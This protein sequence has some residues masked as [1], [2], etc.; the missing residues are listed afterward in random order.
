M[1]FEPDSFASLSQ[2]SSPQ[3][4]PCTEIQDEQYWGRAGQQPADSKRSSVF[5]R[6]Y[7]TSSLR[8]GTVA[9]I[10]QSVL[11]ASIQSTGDMTVQL[12]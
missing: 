6:V 8:K 10:Q 2:T 7:E 4:F 12:L 3:R 9:T 11:R 1:R 5:G